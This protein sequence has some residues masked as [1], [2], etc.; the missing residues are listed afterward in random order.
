LRLRLLLAL[1]VVV[2]SRNAS[3]QLA[4]P[5]NEQVTGITE[6]EVHASDLAREFTSGVLFVPRLATQLF[7][8]ATGVAATLIEEEQVVPRV[9][10]LLHPPEGEVR[11]FPT[12]FA[13]TGSGMN[14]GLRI[15]AH[16]K[17]VAGTV[18][19]GYGGPHDLVVESRL[20]LSFPRPVPI[21][22]GAQAFHDHRSSIGFLGLGQHPE[23]DPRNQFVPGAGTSATYRER[24]QRFIITAG[25][26]PFSNVEFLLSTSYMRRR[27]LDAPDPGPDTIQ[28]VFAPG[29]VPGYLATSQI[30]YSEAGLRYDTRAGRG[31]PAT[32]ALAEA[33]LG[34]GQGVR[35]TEMS[36]ERYGG[37]VAGFFPVTTPANVISPKISIDGMEPLDGQVPFNELVRQP[38]FRGFDNRRDYAS[39]VMSLDYRWML[40]RHIGARLFGDLA[41][42]APDIEELPLDDWR[43]A[44]GFT[45]EVFS[46]S[47]QLG[48]IGFIG[49]TEGFLFVLKFGV[50][51]GF[52]DRQHRG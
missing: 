7:F 5:T 11:I 10:D 3:A 18:R 35:G 45:I 25:F 24:R 39:M 30:N 1:A 19:A 36:Y 9:D 27:V 22:F 15:I 51:S 6:P 41:T 8:T 20:G 14:V 31:G 32:G 23:T 17:N 33:Y 43:F 47:S 16:A 52:G 26:R 29:S 49:S 48:S 50:S 44:G 12:L 2:S 46:R 42:V 34:H 13:E 28:D 40:V 4:A 37:R 21:S 38:D